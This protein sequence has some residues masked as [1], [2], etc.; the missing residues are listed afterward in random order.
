MNPRHLEYFL[1]VVDRGGVGRAAAELGITQPSLSQA[2]RALERDVGLPLFERAGRGLELSDAGHALRG[3]ARRALRGLEEAR[4]S[5]Q[6][7]RGLSVGVLRITA[8]PS[9][10]LSPLPDVLAEFTREHPGIAIHC[11][12][13]FNSPRLIEA[14]QMAHV[15][16][17]LGVDLPEVAGMVRWQVGTQELFLAFPPDLKPDHDG[18]FTLESLD[19]MSVVAGVTGTRTRALVDQAINSGVAITIAAEV[20]NREMVVPL[21]LRGVGCGFLAPEYARMARESGAHVVPLSPP[22]IFPIQQLHREG[23]SSPAAHAFLRLLPRRGSTT[24]TGAHAAG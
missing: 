8:L 2:I 24:N 17:A 9:L 7:V 10:C 3:P 15:D 11:D 20:T 21:I 19:G 23:M 14:V 12:V 6:E 4:E 22:A 5:V 13:A 18:P 16:V 1:A